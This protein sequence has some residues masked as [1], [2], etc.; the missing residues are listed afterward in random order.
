MAA[1]NVVG[2]FCYT[3][4]TSAFL[5][6]PTILHQYAIRH[7]QA[8]EPTVRL[9]DFAFALHAVI[10]TII[11]YSQFWHRLWRFEGEATKPSATAL[12]IIVGSAVGVAIVAFIVW[13]RGGPDTDP[14]AWAT[15]DVVSDIPAPLGQH[16]QIAD[17]MLDLCV[18]ARKAT[19][20]H[21][22]VCTS[23]VAQ[24]PGQ[25]NSRLVH[26]HYPA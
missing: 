8:P 18:L 22:Q 9:N 10:M 24:L 13:T 15:I 14:T 7:P 5:F 1:L 4:S 16:C 20:H 21:R 11:V 17:L 19:H 12:G 23:G 25:V 26:L 2:F 3:I 6:S